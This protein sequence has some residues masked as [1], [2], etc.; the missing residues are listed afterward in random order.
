M[1]RNKTRITR[2][3]I[4][5]IAVVLSLLTTSVALYFLADDHEV[6]VATQYA[7]EEQTYAIND[8]DVVEVAGDSFDTDAMDLARIDLDATDLEMA[9]NE[10]P[11]PATMAMLGLGGL[12]LL[13]RRRNRK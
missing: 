13:R 10:V 7:V 1:K 8:A 4:I 2:V 11:E 12:A 6:R 3:G 9:R 5:S